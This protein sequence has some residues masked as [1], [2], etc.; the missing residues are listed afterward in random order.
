MIAADGGG[1]VRSFPALGFDPAPGEVAVVD[2][3]A[4]DLGKATT[5]LGES[6]GLLTDLASKTGSDWIGE[7]ADAFREHASDEL[8]KALRNAHDSFEKAGNAL[9]GWSQD[10]AEFQRQADSLEREAE[11][12]RADVA[13]AREHLAD[14]RANPYHATGPN[15]D[16]SVVAEAHRMQAQ[17][18]DQANGAVGSAEGSLDDILRRARSLKGHHDDAA[19]SAAKALDSAPDDLAP[20]K[21]G[22]FASIG[23]WI[24]DHAKEIGDILADISAVTGFLALVTPPPLDAICLGVSVVS[25]L[26]AAGFHKYAGEGWGTVGLD[27]VG[28]LPGIG[29]LGDAAK[30]AKLGETVLDGVRFAR[31]AESAG[32]LA[33]GARYAASGVTD[34]LRAAPGALRTG[35][36]EAKVFGSNFSRLAVNGIDR[37][38]GVTV[39]DGLGLAANLDRGVLGTAGV[40][41]FVDLAG[42]SSNAALG[43]DFGAPPGAGPDAVGVGGYLGIQQAVDWAVRAGRM[44]VVQ[45]P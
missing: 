26:G 37:I 15:P 7:A 31:G 6:A 17:A 36:D 9:H 12:A 29:V 13:A 44:P 18:V 10:L 1:S 45:V 30:G 19:D 23:D 8:P 39:R 14:V 21:P 11:Q 16:P 5:A 34:S 43:T 35:L 22:L 24:G 38:P 33:F 28:A 41:G 42:R 40:A 4:E 3:L 25:A 32:D 2:S 20:H 27:M